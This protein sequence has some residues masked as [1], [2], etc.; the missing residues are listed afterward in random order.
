MPALVGFAMKAMR[1]V[2]RSVG[3]KSPCRSTGNALIRSTLRQNG[4]IAIGSL[5]PMRRAIVAASTNPASPT[6]NAEAEMT[7]ASVQ[8]VMGRAYVSAVRLADHD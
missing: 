7:I 6:S 2:P 8:P 3:A 5:V 4:G 1:S